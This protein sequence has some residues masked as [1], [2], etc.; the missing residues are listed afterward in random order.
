MA[1]TLA[2]L[3][4]GTYRPGTNNGQLPPFQYNSP[5][6]GGYFPG[7]SFKTGGFNLNDLMNAYKQFRPFQDV[8]LPEAPTPQAPTPVQA[9][10]AANYKGGDRGL[11]NEIR[12]AMNQSRSEFYDPTHS[13]AFTNLM[14]LAS[15][16]TAR[17]VEETER[18]AR[19]ATARRGYAG[20]Y[21]AETER[22]SRDRMRE[23]AATGFENAAQIRGEAGQL[24]G[25]QM[26]A[27]ASV[28]NAVMQADTEAGI[29]RAGDL[30]KAAMA[31]G[32]LQQ[33]YGQ[34]LIDLYKAKSE[35]ILGQGGLR[36]TGRGHDLE[37]LTSLAQ[38]G[39]AGWRSQNELAL[40][41]SKY[42]LEEQAAQRAEER[43]RAAEEWDFAFKKKHSGE[44]LGMRAAEEDTLNP[45]ESYLRRTAS[46]NPLAA[47]ALER[48]RINRRHTSPP[49]F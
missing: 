24:Y 46:S 44:A 45:Q 23:M 14:S 19:E 36:E 31:N 43:R 15:T 35:A 10:S 13:A 30:L 33:G 48:E 37:A 40:L 29:A 12:G 5:G 47:L 16:K 6:G 1:T 25:Q 34:Q 18:A 3:S 21:S 27:F 4:S 11:L 2:S 41:Q 32:Q 9:P 17:N 26:G 28:A 38:T 7:S 20:G 49:R 39:M 8:N 22:A 42:G